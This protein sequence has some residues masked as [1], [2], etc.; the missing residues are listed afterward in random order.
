M[1]NRIRPGSFSVLRVSSCRNTASESILLGLLTSRSEPGL[2][3]E[4][5]SGLEKMA[6]SHFRDKY[7]K[8]HNCRKLIAASAVL[9]SLRIWVHKEGSKL[10][11]FT[12]AS[13]L[14]LHTLESS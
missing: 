7:Y 9:V 1:R 2:S 14:I 6:Y 10:N 4:E 8:D 5:N 11:I 3:T 12:P 13:A